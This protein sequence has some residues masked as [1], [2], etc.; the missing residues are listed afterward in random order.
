MLQNEE[1]E[2]RFDATTL[3]KRLNKQ[4]N[5]QSPVTVTHILLADYGR[6]SDVT[7]RWKYLI[8]YN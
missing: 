8:N 2:N 3:L 7:I 6:T 5:K 4:T 1:C